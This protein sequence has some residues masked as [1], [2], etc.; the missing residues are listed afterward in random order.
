MNNSEAADDDF[1]L[2]HWHQMLHLDQSYTRGMV[3]VYRKIRPA[4]QV[5]Q[6]AQPNQHHCVRRHLLHQMKQDAAH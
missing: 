1:Q 4:P 5:I 2:V 6:K 3:L